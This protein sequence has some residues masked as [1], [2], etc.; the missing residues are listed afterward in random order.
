MNLFHQPEIRWIEN[1]SP[2]K[3]PF[4]ATCEVVIIHPDLCLT[5]VL[6]LCP[7]HW[8]LFNKSGGAKGK[9]LLRGFQSIGLEIN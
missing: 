8:L 5:P 7:F 9:P 4:G 1:Y 2:H 6:V 3:P